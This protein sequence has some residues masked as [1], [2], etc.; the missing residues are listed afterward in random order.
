MSRLPTLVVTLTALFAFT[1]MSPYTPAANRETSPAHAAAAL[2]NRVYLPVIQV[3]G[4]VLVWTESTANKVQPTTAAGSGR[5]IVLEGARNS[6]EAAQIIV[7]ANQALAGV[8]MSTS[9]LSDG[10][11]HTLSADHLTFF[12]EA[13]IDFAN[14][15]VT[16]HGNLE[17]PQHS[18]SGDSRIPDPLI[19]FV[20]PYTTSTRAVG[21]PFSVASGL[22]Q[23]VWVDVFIPTDTVAGV[24]QGVITVSVS[25][26][27][28]IPVPLTLTV[29]NLILPDM[30]TISTYFGMH[31]EPGLCDYHAGLAGAGSTTSSC[32]VDWTPRA[33][34]VVKRYEELAHASRIDSWPNFVPSQSNGC[35]PPTSWS[36]Y[37]DALR[38]YLDGTYWSNGVPSSW[39][40]TPFSPGTDW[41]P[42]TC[43]QAQYTAL[44]AA[45]ASHLQTNGWLS[46]ALAYAYDEPPPSA[47]PAIAEHAQWMQAG[48][49]AWKARIMDTIAPTASNIATLG[50][51]LGIYTVCIS[52]YGPWWNGA[53]TATTPYGRAEWPGLFA[54]QTQL[55]FYESNA[56]GM[57]YPTFATNTLLGFEPRIMLWGAWYEQATGFLLWDTTYWTKD[58]PWGPNSTWSKT[59]DGVL[60][61][62]GNHDG[63]LAPVG[64]PA[65]VAIDGPIPSYRLKVV[66]DGLQDWALFKL[67]EQ[68]GLAAYARAQ[69]A[70]VYGQMGGCTWQ[71][72][73]PPVNGHFF[74]RADGATMQQV[75]HD[76]AQAIMS[77][78]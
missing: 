63:M 67:A 31:T 34:T 9:P 53:T 3:S 57:P 27:S 78:P 68:R 65:D 47:F 43:T 71:G 61:Y 2:A 18:P 56:Q 6:Y 33:R 60:M 12:R 46:R 66:R 55:W 22:N 69:V 5:S 7:T 36:A 17:V 15:S 14:V 20:D 49:P 54:N 74:W 64:S 16:A 23:P 30:N 51:A 77:A 4:A 25:G 58:Q 35:A 44:A 59:G 10:A 73:P 11:G 38:P 62:P 45:W 70:Q 21:A 1:L 39:F 8:T 26:Q 19:P 50:P 72:C 40:P 28:P 52:C 24:Y 32:W 76:I 13:V 75:R 37:D 42:Q 29:W 48:N 41:G